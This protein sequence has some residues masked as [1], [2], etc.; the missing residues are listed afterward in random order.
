MV[1]GR[2]PLHFPLQRLA[3]KVEG[4]DR[5]SRLLEEFRHT[6][7]LQ[8]LGGRLV[9]KTFTRDAFGDRVQTRPDRGVEKR[10]WVVGH[11]ESPFLGRTGG[12]ETHP[13]AVKQSWLA[14][15]VFSGRP[16]PKS[17]IGHPAWG[18]SLHRQTL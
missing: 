18:V 12:G 17:G 4:D 5:L 8:L 16:L 2:H 3:T 9:L 11:R 7:E 6:S 10:E 14:A 15:V 13:T 1:D